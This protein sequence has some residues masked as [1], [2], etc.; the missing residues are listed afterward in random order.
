MSTW[1]YYTR[2]LTTLCIFSLA[3]VQFESKYSR[4]HLSSERKLIREDPRLRSPTALRHRVHP[5]MP[6][7]RV[8]AMQTVSTRIIWR[9]SL[10]LALLLLL[11]PFTTIWPADVDIPTLHAVAP[12][13]RSVSKSVVSKQHTERNWILSTTRTPTTTTV[14]NLTRALVSA[15]CRVTTRHRAGYQH[16]ARASL[17]RPGPDSVTSAALGSLADCTKRETSSKL[18]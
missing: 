13:H 7:A 2:F 12:H 9:V 1:I 6:L 11:L 15:P 5:I 4:V 14:R 8:N 3:C 16:H 17:P 18:K 10:Q